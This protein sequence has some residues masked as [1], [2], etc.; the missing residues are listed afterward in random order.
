MFA[1][2]GDGVSRLPDE[3]TIR[4]FRHLLEERDASIVSIATG[5]QPVLAFGW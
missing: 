5:R 2:L 1:G 4:R 3:S